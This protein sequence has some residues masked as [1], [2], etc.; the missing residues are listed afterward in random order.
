MYKITVT[1]PPKGVDFGRIKE[2]WNYRELLYFFTWRDIKVR[3]KQTIV[4]IGWAILQPILSML[5]FTLIFGKFAKIPSDELPYPIFAYSGLLP[6]QLF[7]RGLSEASASLVANS[8]VITKVYFPRL[9][10]PASSTISGLLDFSLAFLVLLIL[11]LGFGAKPTIG[12]LALPLFLVIIVLASLSVGI[13]FSAVNV[14][15]RDVRY[16]LP[17]LTQ[18]WFFATPI[19][20]SV[21]IIP[22][23][24][25][26]LM[27]L[28]PMSGVIEG[29]RWALL[30]KGQL[31]WGMVG[32][33][34]VVVLL[35]F[36]GG[37]AYFFKAEREFADVV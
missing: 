19:V 26:I 10:L 15:Y 37:L 29:F 4:G 32:L 21:S 6:W 25:R 16:A 12:I 14:K 7:S 34:L 28:N 33:S 13:L 20:Y 11:M 27:G 8:G 22:E 1:S 36:I 31:E 30:G 9:I 2:I 17:F 23:K 3:Y 5:V 18:V 35:L 24:F